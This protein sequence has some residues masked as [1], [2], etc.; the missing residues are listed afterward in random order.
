MNL[1]LAERNSF[2]QIGR[3]AATTAPIPP[4]VEG[5]LSWRATAFVK[6]LLRHPDGTLLTAREKL[7]LFVLADYHSDHRDCAWAGLTAVA[8]ASL[9]SRRHLLRV[10]SELESKGSLKVTR[11]GMNSNEYRFPEL[12]RDTTSL[13]R[14]KSSKG[15]DTAASPPRDIAM[16][17]KP[18]VNRQLKPSRSRKQGKIILSASDVEAYEKLYL[19]HPEL[20]PEDW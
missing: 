18:S 1:T 6:N 13:P 14:D 19:E 2:G 15:R 3:G 12:P 9:T 4:L 5:F 7:V 8:K 10:I 20:K 11:R 17:P 16:S